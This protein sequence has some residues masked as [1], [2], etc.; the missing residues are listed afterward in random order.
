VKNFF[1]FLFYLMFFVPEI[2]MCFSSILGNQ[3]IHS[4]EFNILNGEP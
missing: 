4:Q 3:E 1:I 2:N